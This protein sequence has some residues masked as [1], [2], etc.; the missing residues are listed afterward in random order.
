[1][2]NRFII[3]CFFLLNC[4]LVS[5]EAQNQSEKH[6]VD[7]IIKGHKLF[8]L[9]ANGHINVLDANSGALIDTNI[10]SDTTIASM[11]LDRKGNIVVVESNKK[12]EILDERKLTFKNLFNSTN[13]VFNIVFNQNNRGY[14][15]TEKGIT[16]VVAKKNY[17]P[18]TSIRLNSQVRGWSKP[19]AVFMDKNDNIWLGY[20]FGEWGGELFVFNTKAGKFIK[21]ILN[22][23]PLAPV[24][25][26]FT[27]GNV[28]YISCGVQ[29]MLT[30]GCIT[31]FTGYSC[32]TIFI[33]DSHWVDNEKKDMRK[34]VEGE[35]I[36]PAIYNKKDTSIYFY[37]QNGLFKGNINKDLSQIS[38]WKKIASPKLHWTNGQPDA[39]GSPMNALKMSLAENGQ[40][41]LVAPND[42]IGVYDGKA[43][44]LLN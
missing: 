41:F 20:G 23:S 22:Q 28:V 42:G 30:Y 16:D 39:V 15:I 19:S 31:K 43:F 40:L 18:D 17:L 4:A 12:I 37:S 27:D 5:C 11:N 2:A 14:I 1:M 21:P 8:A 44:H 32:S 10:H 24:K 29:H 9:T 34:M 3:F 6:Y 25:S 26:I 7:L 38:G 13:S 35:Y 36:G 33:S